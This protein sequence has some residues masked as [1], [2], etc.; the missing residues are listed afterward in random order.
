MTTPTQK[1]S[2]YE[3]Q[4][5]MR[6]HAGIFGKIALNQTIPN[7]AR[8]YAI[9]AAHQAFES[10]LGLR[11][12]HA[13]MGSCCLENAAHPVHDWLASAPTEV[14]AVTPEEL[15]ALPNLPTA[16]ESIDEYA[17]RLNQQVSDIDA[18]GDT[19]EIALTKAAGAQQAYWDALGHLEDVLGFDV[20]TIDDLSVYTVEM[21]QEMEQERLQSHAGDD[22]RAT[23]FADNH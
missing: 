2:T 5:W 17:D 16:E 1:L 12:T 11:E 23:P 13:Y 10:D 9:Q 20:E 15:V 22:D 18:V 3:D 14:V 8:W 21:L 4:E 6:V 7:E 19:P